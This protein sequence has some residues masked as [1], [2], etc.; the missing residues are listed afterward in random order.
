MWINTNQTIKDIYRAFHPVTSLYIFFSTPHVTIS[1]VDY[2][3]G[4]KT[5]LN[6]FKSTEI[7]QTMFFKCNGM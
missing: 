7:T 5:S 1:R 4:D 6:K 3:L 2:I